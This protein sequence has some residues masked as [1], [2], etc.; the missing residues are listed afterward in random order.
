MNIF[1]VLYGILRMLCFWPLFFN[2]Y[3]I[4]VCVNQHQYL[5]LGKNIFF[6]NRLLEDKVEMF[7]AGKPYIR[8]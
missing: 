4:I 1:Q 7:D 3:Y 5:V 8:I 6:E 2:H